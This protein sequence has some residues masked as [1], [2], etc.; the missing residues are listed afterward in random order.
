MKYNYDHADSYYRYTNPFD[1][2]NYLFIGEIKLMRTA[3]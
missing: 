3:I 2:G 1:F